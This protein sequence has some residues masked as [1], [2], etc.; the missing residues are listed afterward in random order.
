MEFEYVL[1]PK[2]SF[3]FNSN[4]Y[5]IRFG[6][7]QKVY[8]ILSDDELLEF[9]SDSI[10]HEHIHKAIFDL[11]END[12]SSTLFDVVQQYF[13]NTKLANKIFNQNGQMSWDEYIERNGFDVF[14]EEKYISD[15][16]F[17]NAFESCNRRW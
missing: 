4:E 11:F 6:G 10:T 7:K 3:A 14:L 13:R 12:T 1:N 15:N 8:D 16:S 17:Y 5:V 2:N 9:I